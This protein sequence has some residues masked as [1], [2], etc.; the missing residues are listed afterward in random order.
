MILLLL[1]ML[2]SANAVMTHD[3]LQSA[4]YGSSKG[5]KADS[6]SRW[7]KCKGLYA[8]RHR[9]RAMQISAGG[10]YCS[11][12]NLKQHARADAIR[13]FWLTLVDM[14]SPFAFSVKL[15]TGAF[16]VDLDYSVHTCGSCSRS[17]MGRTE[18]F[19]GRRRVISE[20]CSIG[21]PLCTGQF[22]TVGFSRMP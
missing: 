14:H 10:R 9:I 20:G 5:Y 6:L 15:P 8:N 19:P 3:Q 13:L 16:V 11:K 18:L 17:C 7:K 1:G 21:Q 22:R 2:V 12:L 4:V